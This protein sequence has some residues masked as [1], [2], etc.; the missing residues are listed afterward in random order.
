MKILTASP[1]NIALAANALRV[2]DLVAVPTETVYG[3]AAD[4]TNDAAVQKIYATKGRPSNNPLIIHVPDADAAMQYGMFNDHA[5]AFA[6]VFWPGPLTLVVPAMENKISAF[7]LNHLSTIALRVPSH[8]VMQEVLKTFAAPLAAPSANRSGQLSP[9]Q[10]NH[11]ADDF[12]NADQP[13]IILAGGRSE[14]GLESTIV[15]CTSPSPRILRPGSIT[16]EELRAVVPETESFTAQKINQDTELLAPGMLDKH[17]APK[18]PLRLNVAEIFEGEALLAFGPEPLWTRRA[19]AM[20]NL[21]PASD[22]TEA[23]HNLFSHLHQLDQANA[24]RIAVMPI[25]NEGIGIAINDR[26]RRGAS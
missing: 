7:A 16:I 4:A 23:A 9:T 5:R 26:L 11:V 22:L 15:D 19:A 21:S 20:L 2:G 8:P 18:T 6:S 14:T 12:K 1:E 25:P 10:A 24:K 13:K 3:L 17:Y